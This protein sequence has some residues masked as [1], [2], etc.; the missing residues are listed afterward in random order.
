MLLAID[1][2]NTN[3]VVALFEENG[4]VNKRARMLKEWRISTDSR[5]TGDEYF[6]FLSLLF[7]SENIADSDIT[8]AVVSSV[9]PALVGTFVTVARHF[10]GKKPLL[11]NKDIYAFLPITLPPPV[12]HEVGTDLL[13]NALEAW[14]RYKKATIVVDFGTALTFTTVD[15]HGVLQGVAIAPGL[16][17]AIKSLSN[18]TAQLPLVEL[19]A[20]AT[21]L[22]SNTIEC[23]QAGVILGYKGLVEYMIERT[24][25]DLADRTGVAKEDVHVVATGGLNSV[26]QPLVDCFEDFDREFTLQGLRRAAL[27][28]RGAK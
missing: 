10:T 2:G 11:I 28:V 13:C 15:Q 24:K 23:I 20:P 3:V 25:S 1:I 22:G 21:S 19:K 12:E 7:H 4:D 14:C 26:L 8:D 16:G 17:T 27:F 18:N 9:V 6:S 5:R